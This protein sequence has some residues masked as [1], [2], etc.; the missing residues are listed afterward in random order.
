MKQPGRRGRE[1]G[2][3]MV[4]YSL[5]TWVLVVALV[6]GAT[7]RMIPSPPGAAPNGRPV[8]FIELFLWSL[9]VYFDS[10][11]FVLDLPF[12]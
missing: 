1:R 4:E 9:Q 12:P 6:L 5:M 10:Y 8:N 2:Q 11:Q 3:A 7:V